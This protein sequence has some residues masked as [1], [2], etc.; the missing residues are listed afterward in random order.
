MFELTVMKLLQAALD[1]IYKTTKNEIDQKTNRMLNMANSKSKGKPLNISQMVACLGQQVVDGKR[2][3]LGFTDRTLPHFNKYDDGPDSRG[4][5][6]SSFMGGLNA[7]EF[8]FVQS[9][10]ATRNGS[11]T[12]QCGIPADVSKRDAN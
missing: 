3:S 4:F 10:Q 6:N 8:F 5:V 7:Q 2:V 9:A 1:D 12:A 11:G